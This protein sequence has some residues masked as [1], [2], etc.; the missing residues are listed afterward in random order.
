MT[1]FW[2]IG[3][4]FFGEQ[5]ITR[6]KKPEKPDTTDSLR[7]NLKGSWVGTAAHWNISERDPGEEV[8]SRRRWG[9]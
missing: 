7:R 8:G 3:R 2:A 9:G 6:G 1:S 5:P 4:C